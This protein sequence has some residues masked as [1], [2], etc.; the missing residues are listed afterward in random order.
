[1]PLTITLDLEDSSGVNAPD[2]RWVKATDTF[3]DAL[4]ERQIRATVFV[5]GVAARACPALV[6]RVVAAG[7][8]IGLHGLRHVPLGESGP[9]RLPEELRAGRSLLQ[10]LTGQPVAGFRAP[11]FSLTPSTAW[12]IDALTDVGFTYDSSILPARSPLHGW[13]GLPGTPFSWS[14][15]LIEFP[16]PV[17]GVG[18]ARV[19]YLGGIYLRYVPLVVT[20]GQVRKLTDAAAPWSYVHPYDLDPGAPVA[21]LPHANWPTS[22]LLHTRRRATL[23]R[24]DAVL[25][26]AGGPAPT[27]GELSEALVVRDLEQVVAR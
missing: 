1:M 19:P 16:C 17:L 25:T 13:P 4:A 23:S 7:H 21:R 8:E 22:L 2:G 24:L 27:L 18:A 15:G 9:V 3:L 14:S 26:A 5:V 12:A 20:R 11:I 6:R 10:D